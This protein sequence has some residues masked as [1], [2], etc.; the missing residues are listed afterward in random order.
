MGKDL[1]ETRSK[2]E[3]AEEYSEKLIQLERRRKTVSVVAC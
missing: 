3:T 1:F 2:C